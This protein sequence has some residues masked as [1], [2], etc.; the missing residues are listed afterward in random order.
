MARS[1]KTWRQALYRRDKDSALPLR[2]ACVADISTT[3][4]LP[5]IYFCG[6]TG[7][8]YRNSESC[9]S[10][11]GRTD[12]PNKHARSLAAAFGDVDG[13]GASSIFT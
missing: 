5:D 13:D 3:T 7:K 12:S 4:A 10:K 11:T 1:T 6:G 8:L 9:A 2:A